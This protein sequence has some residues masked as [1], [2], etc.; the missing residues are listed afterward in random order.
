MPKVIA[1]GTE[2]Q[3]YFDLF[4]ESCDRYNIE[5][6]ILGW[7]EKWVGHGK[8][9]TV[10]RDYI[11]TLPEKEIIIVVDPFDVIFL[12]GPDEIENKFN[13]ISS[14]FLCGALNLG[15]LV[16]TLYNYEFNKTGKKVPVT[17][18]NYNFLNS[19]TWISR[20][21]YALYLIDE[22][23]DKFHM[24]DDSMD[25]QLL[26]DIYIRKLY[27]VDIDWKC[28]IFHNL[29]F[30]DFI[31]RRAD[32]KDLKFI[33]NR[34]LNT[35]SGSKPCIIHASDNTNMKDLALRLGYPPNIIKPVNNTKNFTRKAIFHLRQIMKSQSSEN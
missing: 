14:S 32:L 24:N 16:A 8:K 21:G 1:F 12:C 10:I 3:A 6:V 19:G 31:T 27:S 22:L 18:T 33:D 5:P 13:R 4:R 17:P 9:L 15:K 35:A 25:Q 7:N 11:K 28:E 30:K 2:K 34:V 20:A 23:V 26:T 29:L